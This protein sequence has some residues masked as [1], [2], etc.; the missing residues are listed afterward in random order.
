MFMKKILLIC[1]ILPVLALAEPGFR[2][3]GSITGVLNGTVAITYVYGVSPTQAAS[4]IALPKVSIKDGAFEFTGHLAFPVLVDLKISTRK[5]RV[6]LENTSYSI[7]GD[8]KGLSCASLKGG[9]ANNVWQSYVTQGLSMDDCIREN[10]NNIIAAYLALIRS[11]DTRTRAKEDFKILGKDARNSWYGRQLKSRINAYRA[12]G[13]GAEFPKLITY[14]LDG[15]VFSL[16]DLPRKLTV[17]DFWASWCAPCRKFI[18]KLESMYE[19]Y[20]DKGVRFVSVS[21][22]DDLDH[23]KSAVNKEKMPW[24]QVIAKDGFEDG[25]GIKK[26]LNIFNIP[27]LIVVDKEGKIVASL[28]AYQKD[29]L[30]TILKSKL[31]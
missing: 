7:T 27:Y 31:E 3:K 10:A 1:L 26:M 12:T 24:T 17:L 11:K 25:K 4:I 22:D 5:I 14:G 20:K 18:P 9:V 23:W 8:F 21:V 2:I 13:V 30:D 19:K 15:S 16:S 28:D 29:R 6:F